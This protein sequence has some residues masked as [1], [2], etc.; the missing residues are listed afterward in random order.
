V[1]EMVAFARANPGAITFGTVGA[2]TLNALNSI[3]FVEA[4]GLT[5]LVTLVPYDGGAQIRT[6]LLGNHVQ[7]SS[8]AVGDVRGI[9]ESGDCT[10]LG[11]IGRQ[12]TGLM[13][14]VPTTV[15]LGVPEVTTPVPRGFFAPPGT[16]APILDYLAG[17]FRAAIQN[18]ECVADLNR[19]FIDANFVDRHTGVR[20]TQAIFN[21]L[22]PAFQRYFP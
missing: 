3:R 9:I 20:E 11:I 12:R 6:A 14:N 5:D 10:P 13:P 19:M 7:V 1:P 18:P 4:L 17:V 16:P 21:D 22:Q 8:N 2:R 15:E